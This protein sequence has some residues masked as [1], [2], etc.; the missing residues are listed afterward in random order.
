MFLINA[1]IAWAVA[2]AVWELVIR[3]VYHMELRSEQRERV[4]KAAF[5]GLWM[6]T[7]L[8]SPFPI[9]YW[10]L[11]FVAAALLEY[12]VSFKVYLPYE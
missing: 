2:N 10:L 4:L 7:F 11:L 6:F 8:A 5:C 3:N 1:V 12:A 9:Q